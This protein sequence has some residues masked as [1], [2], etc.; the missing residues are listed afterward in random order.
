MPANWWEG[1]AIG[2]FRPTRY[3]LL[4]KVDNSELAHATTWDMA[5]F[6]RDDGQNR[7]GLLDLEVD[8]RHRRKGYGRHL[9]AEILRQARN[10][11]VTI[12]AVQTNANNSPALSPVRVAPLRSGRDRHP[13]SPTGD[14]LA[15]G[16]RPWMWVG[17]G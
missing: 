9:V 5:W 1:L 4:S 16:S 12:V 11:T 13:L 15:R 7:L 3:R 8:A 17:R 6:G 2:E 10:D 14:L